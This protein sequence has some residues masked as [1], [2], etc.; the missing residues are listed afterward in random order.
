MEVKVVYFN[1]FIREGFIPGKEHG[2]EAGGEY[3]SEKQTKY[4]ELAEKIAALI[5]EEHLQPGDRLYSENELCDMFSLSRQ[6][7]RR[8]VRILEE[9]GLATRVRGSGTYIAE[10]REDLSRRSGRI[11]VVST[12]VD[13]YIFSRIIQGMESELSGHGYSVQISFTG[14]RLDK[15]KLVLEDILEGNGVAGIIVEATKSGL[16]NPNLDL[17]RRIQERKIPMIFFNAFYP[18]LEAPHVALNDER[19][20]YKAVKYLTGRGHRQIGAILKLD[21]GQGR[22]RY[23]GYL[24]A[25]EEAN[26]PAED[27]RI[28]WLDSYEMQQISLCADRFWNRL[29]SCTALFCYNDQVAFQLIQLLTER[30]IRVPEDVSVISID[31]SDLARLSQVPI[32]SLP[33]PKERLGAK[34]AQQL[35]SMIRGRSKDITYEFETRVVERSSVTDRPA[36]NEREMNGQEHREVS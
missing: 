4:Q 36:E 35:L 12:Y 27:A 14:N 13:S 23:L 25:M 7:V 32:T 3:M 10:P 6:T 28:V 15:E 34:T 26:L 11:A 9:E 33:H 31:D 20:A 2:A 18:E 24:K 22:L 29:E 16:P 19:A 21:D 8:A 17:Y 30:G 1:Q 5:S